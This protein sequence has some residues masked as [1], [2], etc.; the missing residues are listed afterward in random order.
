MNLAAVNEATKEMNNT[1]HV[2]TENEKNFV[3][4]FA[5][6]CGDMDETVAL[7][8]ALS[9]AKN[10]DETKQL[11][12]DYG[13]KLEKKPSWVEQVENLLIALE[14]YRTEEERAVNRLAEILNAYGIDVS[15]DEIRTTETEVLKTT[16]REKVEVR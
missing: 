7:I 4:H 12:K 2:F 16:V 9:R 5:I 6:A 13:D 3:V 8:G 11:M 15:E 1:D 14:M 10:E